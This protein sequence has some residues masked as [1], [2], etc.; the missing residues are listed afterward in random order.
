M[1]H[2]DVH[3]G[4]SHLAPIWLQRLYFNIVCSLYTTHHQINSFMWRIC[5]HSIYIMTLTKI[6]YIRSHSFSFP[7]QHF[8]ALFHNDTHALALSR[9]PSIASI[10]DRTRSV[11]HRRCQW[12]HRQPQRQ[13]TVC[14]F[15]WLNVAI[16]WA[17][18]W[19]HAPR[20]R[21]QQRSNMDEFWWI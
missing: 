5:K 14:T 11:C 15:N 1:P 2:A 18:N 13:F 9:S 10:F 20:R 3:I 7:H 21:M 12:R 4:F 16:Y 19:R 6:I 17:D 8:L